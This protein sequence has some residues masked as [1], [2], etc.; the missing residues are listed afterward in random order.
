MCELAAT[1]AEV[2]RIVVK[3]DPEHAS[4]VDPLRASHDHALEMDNAV[5]FDQRAEA[6]PIKRGIVATEVAD[7]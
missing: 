2:G 6:W 5:L 4:P 3:E 7:K 1:Q